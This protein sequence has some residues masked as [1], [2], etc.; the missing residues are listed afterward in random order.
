MISEMGEKYAV[1]WVRDIPQKKDDREEREMEPFFLFYCSIIVV[2]FQR[3]DS[4]DN[5]EH[6]PS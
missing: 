2:S 4:N 1:A 5:F 3:F 6:V